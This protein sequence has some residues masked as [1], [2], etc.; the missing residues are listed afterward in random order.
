[1]VRMRISKTSNTNQAQSNVSEK[2]S[3]ESNGSEKPSVQ[4]EPSV[5]ADIVVGQEVPQTD[6]KQNQGELSIYGEWMV[7]KRGPRCLAKQRR[8]SPEDE[9]SRQDRTIHGSDPGKSHSG[10]P[11][12]KEK[13]QASI[14]HKKSADNIFDILGNFEE[15]IRDNEE[16]DNL[17]EIL[18]PSVFS[19]TKN[20]RK[21]KPSKAKGEGSSNKVLTNVSRK[22]LAATIKPFRAATIKP[23]RADTTVDFSK[24]S[25][26]EKVKEAQNDKTLKDITNMPQSNLGSRIMK[27]SYSGTKG[28]LKVSGLGVENESPE[29]A[30]IPNKISWRSPMWKRVGSVSGHPPDPIRPLTSL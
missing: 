8:T 20:P 19:K 3:N 18:A 24:V 27:N 1:M 12:L 4:E 25:I 15:V 11:N 14:L 30:R 6:L 23:F 7:A 17:P 5:Q 13:S 21:E 22:D 26:S 28:G 10:Q 9:K 29:E 16:K 2:H